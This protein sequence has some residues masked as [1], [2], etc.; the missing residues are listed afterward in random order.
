MSYKALN[1]KDQITIKDKLASGC[2]VRGHAVIRETIND[3]ITGKVIFDGWNSVL[4]P[5]SWWTALKYFP[6]IANSTSIIGTYDT[7]LVLDDGTITEGYTIE[8]NDEIFLFCVGID[9][10]GPESTQIYPVVKT[11]P[12]INNDNFKNLIPFRY[13]PLGSDNPN[14][15]LTP[16]ERAKYFGAR[17]FTAENRV[18]WYFK[19]FDSE[20]TCEIK[21]ADGTEIPTD[22]NSMYATNN[23]DPTVRVELRFKVEPKDLREYFKAINAGQLTDARINTISIC[24]A[25]RAT[26]QGDPYLYYKQIR[27]ITRLNFTT[28]PLYD[29]TKGLD[30][31]YH[32][33]F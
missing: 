10:A 24:S 2:G 28:E 17:T 26:K 33:Y 18:A 31:I 22:L 30:I 14:D 5:G 6:R 13:L 32:L 20:P 23:V 11:K 3:K 16:E 12:I 9:G 21:F 19:A 27:P 29:P 7:S 15:N 25:H 8:E 1:L 4:I